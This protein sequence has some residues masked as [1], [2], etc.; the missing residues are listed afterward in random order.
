MAGKHNRLIFQH[1]KVKKFKLRL[2]YATDWGTSYV[3]FFADNV[4]VVADGQTI[5]D[6][7]AEKATSPFTL[8]GLQ[9]L[10]VIN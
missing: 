5:V 10:M 6:D 9:K 1:M 3:G 7:G 4:K 2:R 8:N